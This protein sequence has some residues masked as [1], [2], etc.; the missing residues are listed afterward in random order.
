MIG[1][2]I[3]LTIRMMIFAVKATI[4][5]CILM[6]WMVLALIALC[7]KQRPPRLRLPD[8]I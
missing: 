2:M 7:T 4:A 1:L 3:G 5:T 6:V 8:L